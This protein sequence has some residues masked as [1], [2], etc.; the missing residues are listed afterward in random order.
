MKKPKSIAP[1]F[2]TGDKVVYKGQTGLIEDF[3]WDELDTFMYEVNFK[4]GRSD[5]KMK[6]LWVI[7]ESKLES[8]K[9]Y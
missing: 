7:K 6:G 3:W 9:N 5:R 2:D 1:K 4:F 8:K